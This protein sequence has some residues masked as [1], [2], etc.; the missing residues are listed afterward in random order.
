[1]SVD[2][3]PPCPHLSYLDR[4]AGLRCSCNE[5]VVEHEV[6]QHEPKRAPRSRVMAFLRVFGPYLTVAAAL[7]VVGHIT[8]AIERI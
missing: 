8:A 2:R 5:R 3:Q 1:M 6:V 7:I 4:A